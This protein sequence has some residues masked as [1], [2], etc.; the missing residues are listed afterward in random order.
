MANSE[1]DESDNLITP[2]MSPGAARIAWNEIDWDA[3]I[4]NPPK[5]KRV[6]KIKAIFKYIGRSKAIPVKSDG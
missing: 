5:P 1:G 6:G 4:E 2:R 3:H